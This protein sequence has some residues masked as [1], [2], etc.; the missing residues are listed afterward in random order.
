MSKPKH[1]QIR[2]V[3]ITREGWR[4][5]NLHPLPVLQF[6]CP[7]CN[8]TTKSGESAMLVL[9][10]VGQ[11]AVDGYRLGHLE[12]LKKFIKSRIR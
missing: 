10:D 12:C 9:R 8:L 2:I 3:L 6:N 5:F 7:L 1:Y 4:E 11:T